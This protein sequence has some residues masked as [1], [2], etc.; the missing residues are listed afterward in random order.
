[1]QF[2]NHLLTRVFFINFFFLNENN[3]LLLIKTNYA[4]YTL[5]TIRFIVSI[6]FSY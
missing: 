6:Y 4:L 1:M 5:L 2:N 3:K